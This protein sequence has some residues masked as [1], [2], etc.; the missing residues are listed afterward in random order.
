[1]VY[2]YE[3]DFKANV[4]NVNGLVSRN[5]ERC[6]RKIAADIEC[7]R[8]AQSTLNGTA[9]AEYAQMKESLR[10]D[11]AEYYDLRF[12]INQF[13]MK[14]AIENGHVDYTDAEGS[15]SLKL[16]DKPAT[17]YV[18][19]STERQVGSTTEKYYWLERVNPTATTKLQFSNNNLWNPNTQAA[20][21]GIQ[22][23]PTLPDYPE[24]RW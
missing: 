12:E 23:L 13:L 2:Y 8:T 7:L 5:G 15:T 19:A 10:Q 1:M 6:K 9:M 22:L 14:G 20:A 24:L 16:P 21:F 17:F 4:P 18:L 11:V 3:S